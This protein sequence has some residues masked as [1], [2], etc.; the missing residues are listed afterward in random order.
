VE[1]DLAEAFTEKLS[2]VYRYVL[3]NKEKDMVP[4]STE[5][6]FMNSYVFLLNIRFMGK[7]SVTMSIDEARS[8]LMILP[9]ALQLL[10]ENAI[11]HNT[12][13]KANPLNISISIDSDNFLVIRNN[14]Q[15]RETQIQSTGV[16]LANITNRYRLISDRVPVFEKTDK[17]FIAKVPLIAEE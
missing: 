7:I 14:T 10:I 5:L 16:G 8:D 4:L 3:E 17:E 2:K 15:I 6:D 13:S 12:F 11:K 1:P 9:M